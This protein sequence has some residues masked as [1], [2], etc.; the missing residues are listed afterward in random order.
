MPLKLSFRDTLLNIRVKY[1][2]CQSSSQWLFTTAKHNIIQRKKHQKKK[3]IKDWGI[4]R[5]LF[6]I[7]PNCIERC[8]G[9]ECQTETLIVNMVKWIA[10]VYS[11]EAHTHPFSLSIMMVFP[12]LDV[13]SSSLNVHTVTKKENRIKVFLWFFSP[14][15]TA[16]FSI[17][18]LKWKYIANGTPQLAAKQ[19]TVLIF[20]WIFLTCHF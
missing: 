5:I 17:L 15:E 18:S 14:K 20:L 13:I 4:C 10:S 9:E 7:Y 6:F 19:C 2:S 16:S 8:L 12:Q 11:L 3:L 1:S